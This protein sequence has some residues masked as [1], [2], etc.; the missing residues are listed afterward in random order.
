MKS[1]VWIKIEMIRN[2]KQGITEALKQKSIKSKSAKQ[3]NK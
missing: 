3:T 1:N 2:F